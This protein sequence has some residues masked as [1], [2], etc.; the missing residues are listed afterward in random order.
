[1]SKIAQQDN[2]V[3]EGADSM[4]SAEFREY[5]HFDD[6][7]IL[8]ASDDDNIN[9]IIQ[10]CNQISKGNCHVFDRK[11]TNTPTLI[12]KW[13]LEY[14]H[15]NVMPRLRYV[16]VNMN[17]I[18]EVTSKHWHNLAGWT[19]MLHTKALLFSRCLDIDEFPNIFKRYT[20][21]IMMVKE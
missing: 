12:S 15:G 21:E 7:V 14:M 4:T 13:S 17:D 6:Y 8:H 18:P 9:E 19:P 5:Y 3:E 20:R 11:T 16:I 10:F 1:M 2:I